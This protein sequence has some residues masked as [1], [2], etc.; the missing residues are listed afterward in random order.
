MFFRIQNI[1]TTFSLT[2]EKNDDFEVEFFYDCPGGGPDECTGL[3]RD[4]FVNITARVKVC[5]I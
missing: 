3:Q 4:S 1:V 2:S 5:Y